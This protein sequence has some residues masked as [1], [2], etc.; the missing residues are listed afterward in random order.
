MPLIGI[1]PR[2]SDY[3]MAH[4]AEI[5][6]MAMQKLGQQKASLELAVPNVE[7]AWKTLASSISR[8]GSKSRR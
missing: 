7:L 5:V 6:Q 2:T 4:P 3:A 8:C 1:P